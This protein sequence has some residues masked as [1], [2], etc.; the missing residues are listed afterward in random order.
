MKRSL[1]TIR[2]LSYDPQRQEYDVVI[3]IWTPT[4]V[5]NKDGKTVWDNRV[6]RRAIAKE[7]IQ[8]MFKTDK[9]FVIVDPNV[10]YR[11]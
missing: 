9:G 3:T 1:R 10:E 8:E 7:M 5:K 6:Q 2:I 11:F 4:S